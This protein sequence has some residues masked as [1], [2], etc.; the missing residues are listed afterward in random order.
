MALFDILF[1]GTFTIYQLVQDFFHCAGWHSIPGDQRIPDQVSYHRCMSACGA[2]G[3]WALA[4]HLLATMQLGGDSGG[5]ESGIQ[6]TL[7]ISPNDGIFWVFTVP[8]L[9]FDLKNLKMGFSPAKHLQTNSIHPKI[10]SERERWDSVVYGNSVATKSGY[11][12]YCIALAF[13]R[14][15]WH[16]WCCQTYS[17]R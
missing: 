12:T 4:V 7:K 3:L 17:A 14:K 9:I 11:C 10:S 1:H 8:N 5:W 16:L 13:P 2:A 6:P 15:G